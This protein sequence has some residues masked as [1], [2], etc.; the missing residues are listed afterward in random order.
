MHRAVTPDPRFRFVNVAQLESVDA[1]RAVVN[2][3]EFRA[4]SAKM[5]AFHPTPALYTVAVEHHADAGG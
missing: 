2:E 3:P 1:W 5:A 4:I